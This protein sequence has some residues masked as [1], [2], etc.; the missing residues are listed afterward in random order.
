MASLHARHSRNCALGPAWTSPDAAGCNCLPSYYIIARDDRG[1]QVRERTGRNR[2]EAERALR[3]VA[4]T[5]DEGSYVPQVNIAFADWADAWADALERKSATIASYRS[6]LSIAKAVF[7]PKAVRR[8]TPDDVARFSRLLA[9]RGLSPSTRA[10]HLRVLSAC[11]SSAG[12]RHY[13]GRNVVKELPAAEKP[14]AEK[15]EAAYFTDDELPR[16]FAELTPGSRELFSFLLKTGCRVGE[17]SAL[18]WAEIDLAAAVA[19]VRRSYTAGHL[20]TP[21]NHERRDIDLTPDLVELLGVHWGECGKPG[22]EKIV[23]PG[24]TASGHLDPSSVRRELYRAMER[25]G[26]AREGPTGENR[27]VHSLRHTFARIALENGAELT[28]LSR[29]LGHSSTAV[30]DLVY[31]H[32]CRAARKAQMEKLVGAFTV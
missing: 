30:T 26:I 14:R 21:K 24:G 29:H 20:S 2:R 11:L 17:A 18:E 27:T 12:V 10:K 32:W 5:V 19:H 6:T 16:L 9:E 8:L 22:D 1:K 23:F 7:G 28:W 31:G 15:K 4:V 13:A 3:K 25:A